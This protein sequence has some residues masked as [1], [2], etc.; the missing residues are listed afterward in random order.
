MVGGDKVVTTRG[1]RANEKLGRRVAVEACVG[2]MGEGGD[3]AWMVTT[4]RTAS[5]ANTGTEAGAVLR[6]KRL[7]LPLVSGEGDEVAGRIVC[8]LVV[9]ATVST[10]RS[11]VF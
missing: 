6:R 7:G 3:R 11:G 10:T 5:G 9:V 1:A 8:S 2:A 4:Q